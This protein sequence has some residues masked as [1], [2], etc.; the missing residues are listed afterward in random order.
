MAER[1]EQLV[2]DVR[3]TVWRCTACGGIEKRGVARD[4][5][6]L[7]ANATAPPV[8]SAA[9]LR[10]RTQSG[11]SIWTPPGGGGGASTSQH[12]KPFAAIPKAPR[13]TLRA[14]DPRPATPPGDSER[15]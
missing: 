14:D 3:H 9:F 10:R 15:L 6:G 12:R 7:I 2:G 11:M 8:G 13:L 1:T 4:V 5:R